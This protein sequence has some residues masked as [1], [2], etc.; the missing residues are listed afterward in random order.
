MIPRAALLV[1]ILQFALS[2]FAQGQGVQPRQQAGRVAVEPQVLEAGAKTTLEKDTIRVMLP[3]SAVPDPGARVVVWLASPKDVRSGET[4]ATVNTNGRAA[5]AILPWPKDARGARE[6]DIGWY[7]VGYRVDLNETERSHGVL[8]VGAITANLME[9]RL[10]YP[11]LIAQGHALSAR[12]IAVNPVTGKALPRVNLKATLSDDEDNSRK[13]SFTRVATT[14]RDG[15]AIL[16]FAPLGKPG[17]SLDLT[18]EGTLTGEGGALVRDSVNGDVEV[19]DLGSMHVEMDKPLHKPGETVHLRALA[20][21]D[22]GRAAADKPVTVTVTDPDNKTLAK[23]SLKSNR[24]GI[25]A[26]DWETTEQTATGDYEVKFDLDNVTGGGGDATQEV[27]IQRY[28]LP[29]FSVMAT[30]DRAFYLTGEEPKVVI[31]A[32]YLFGKPVA[33]GSVRLVRADDAEWNS[34][35][36]RYDEPKE[37]ED[38]AQLDANGDATVTLKV[39]DEFDQLKSDTWERFRDVKYRAMVTDAT[40]GRTEPRN[41][42]V[43]LTKEPVHI[44]LNPIGSSEREGEYLIS[45]SFAD[46][47]PAP[48]RVT[49]DWMDAQSRATRA[50][51]VKTN[52]Y[53]LA[54]VTLHF[55]SKATGEENNR[56]N[57]RVT[58]RDAE[59]RVSHFDDQL[60]TGASE[61]IWLSLAHTLMRP[62]E[63]IEGTIHARPGT[64]VDIDILSE[65]AVV[66]HWQIRMSG[67]E[68]PFTIPTNPAFHELITLRGYNLRDEARERRW[69]GERDG[70]ARSVLYPEDRSLSSGVKGLAASYAPGAKVSTCSK[71]VTNTAYG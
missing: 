8:S 33:A 27:R 55:P 40:T 28:E 12:V 17:N 44:Y 61:G 66:G 63:P 60:W 30:P 41:F 13:E 53:G 45:T 25:V 16:T 57:I 68:Q 56:P 32:G 15:E 47:T 4:V 51:T 38:K 42:A 48:C 29:E 18:V 21:I 49:L 20:F 54:K 64:S 36:G 14:R 19:M 2:S 34:K 52:R 67:E 31:H 1:S 59:G 7:R 35:T 23:A 5:S 6:E 58:A 37:V 50:M 22:G 46:G 11:K 26:Y 43:R 69:Y 71:T 62:G 24:F 3:L 39:T 10:A 70:T 65:T 9:L